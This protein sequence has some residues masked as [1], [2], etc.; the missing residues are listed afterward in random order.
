MLVRDKKTGRFLNQKKS[1]EIL[2]EKKKQVVDKVKKS[3]MLLMT[4]LCGIIAIL[5]FVHIAECGIIFYD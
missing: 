1:N 3:Y 4:V 5:V 2:A